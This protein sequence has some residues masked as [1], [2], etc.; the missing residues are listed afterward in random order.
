MKKGLS[1]IIIFFLIFLL[2]Q[3]IITFF[4]TKHSSFYSVNDNKYA[5]DIEEDF[6]IINKVH[7]YNFTI[8]DNKKNIYNFNYNKDLNK[9]KNIIKSIKTYTNNGL[10]CIVPIFKRNDFGNIY[11]SRDKE[12][13]SYTYL[14]NDSD[15]KVIL[16]SVKKDKY[17]KNNYI[18]NNKKS[19]LEKTTYYKENIPSN[20][21]F[22]LWDYFGI[23]VFT[24]DEPRDVKLLQNVDSYDNSFSRIVGKYYVALS[25][26][27]LNEI[28]YYNL[29]DDGEKYIPVDTALSGNFLVLGI[30]EN[31]LYIVDLD[32]NKEL[33]IDPYKSTMKE[34]GNESDG[35]LVLN[36]GSLEEIET[37]TFK[38]KM[39]D[40][41]FEKEISN[42]KIINKYGEVEQKTSG[43]YYFF[44]TKDNTFYR[45]S[46]K[47][48]DK[49]IKLFKTGNVSTWKV[50]DD[51][52]IFIS[53]N[54]L[55]FYSDDY[56]L[57]KVL[58]N[59]ELKYNYKNICDLYI[60]N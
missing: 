5:Y 14:V 40:Y 46:S 11:C 58:S 59:N 10:K 16:D 7:M 35:Y 8:K 53:G 37:S 50:V 28:H 12:V 51:T 36:N 41:I 4:I 49:A 38:S 20:Y 45:S 25:K 31:K 26:K 43:N 32:S 39:N 33:V 17:Y 1:I 18:S 60:I 56:S 29:K 55:Y 6:S 15:F 23:D 47:Y 34:V 9:Q 30:F 44:K 2:F 48:P 24:N 54:T 42:K 57:K 3:I 27:S 13:L 21:R 52:I 22:I 19:V